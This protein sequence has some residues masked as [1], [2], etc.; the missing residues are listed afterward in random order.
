[1]RTS[2]PVLAFGAQVR[3]YLPQRRLSGGRHDRLRQR[4]HQLSTDL[5]AVLLG[6][7]STPSGSS[8]AGTGAITYHHV[9]IRI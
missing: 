4:V 7:G 5:G 6:E 1:M 2:G 9:Y 8:P 3:V